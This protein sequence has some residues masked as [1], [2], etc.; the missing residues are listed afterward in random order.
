MYQNLALIN[1]VILAIMIFCNGMLAHITGPYLGTLLFHGLGL[2]LIMA[3]SL[4]KRN[5]LPRL[6]DVPWLLFLP[7]VLNVITILFNNLA[8][9]RIG[10]TLVT[11]VGLFGQL[12]MSALVEHFGLFGMPVNRFKKAKILGFSIISLGIILMI[13]L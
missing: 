9:A 7:G 1:G 13:A 11:G 5:R 12:V 2:A 3:I 4:L 6:A 10:I 8:I